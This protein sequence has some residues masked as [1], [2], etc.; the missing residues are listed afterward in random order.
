M[1]QIVPILQDA[2]KIILESLQNFEKVCYFTKT[3]EVVRF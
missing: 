2:I 3:D 1:T